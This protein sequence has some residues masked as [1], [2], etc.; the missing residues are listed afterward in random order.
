MLQRAANHA[1]SWWWA[2]HIRT[3]QSKWLEQSLQDM[4]EKV[5][6]MLQLI[7]GDGDSFAKRAEMYYRRRPELICSVEEAYKVF[8]AL[9]DRYDLLSKDFQNANHTI[10]T[11]FPEQMQ[12]GMSMT[13]DDDI[14]KIPEN[15]VIPE[16]NLAKIPQ[17]PKAPAK[18]LK[19]I[20]TKASKQFQVKK[21]KS[22]SQGR[23]VVKSGL[24]KDEALDEINK[25]QKEILSLQTVKEFVKSSYENGIAKYWGIESQV[26]EMHQKISR[27]QDEFN[28]DSVIEDEEA[29]TLIAEA[30]LKSCQETLAMLQEKQDKTTMEARQEYNRIQA[31]CD[32]LQ[33]L[34]DKYMIQQTHNIGSGSHNWS[35]DVADLLQETKEIEELPEKPEENLDVSSLACLSVT[36]LAEKIDLLVNK[37]ITLETAVSSQTVL[38]N[39]L[40]SENDDLN[41]QITNL[42]QG[43]HSITDDTQNISTKV[44]EMEEKLNKVQD[45]T[46]NVEIRNNTL[47]TNFARTRTSLD[48]LSEKLTS[49]KEDDD[50]E[51]DEALCNR[52]SA[53][54]DEEAINLDHHTSPLE[55]STTTVKAEDKEMEAR[56][57][58]DPVKPD[59]EVEGSANLD[60]DSEKSVKAAEEVETHAKLDHASR[61]LSSGNPD[62]EEDSLTARTD[63]SKEDSLTARKARGGVE[64]A[65]EED[66][67]KESN[68]VGRSEQEQQ[69]VEKV[70]RKTGTFLNRRTVEEVLEDES[71]DSVQR[72]SKSKTQTIAEADDEDISW[73]QILLSG[74][75][76]R[77]KILLKEYTTI[78]RNYKEVKKKLNDVEK[79]ERDSQFDMTIQMRELKKAISK[80][81]EEIMNLRRRLMSSNGNSSSDVQ[82][83][84]GSFQ[85]SSLMEDEGVQSVAKE[86]LDM[87]RDIK[88]PPI[89]DEDDEESKVIFISKS[90]SMSR[91]EEK[92]RTH[93]DAILDENLDFWFRFSTAFHQIQ[94]FKT[95]VR[96]LEDEISRHREKRKP[97]IKSEVMPIYK[98]LGEI[99]RELTVWLDQSVPLKDEL[100]NRFAS[101]CN[102]QEEITKA[103]K[104]GMEEDEI[105]FSS[106]QAA[107]L[108]GEVLNMKQ[109]NDKVR[110]EL[111]AGLD[112]VSMLQLQ[113]EK[114][115]TQLNQEFGI[116]TDQSEHRNRVPLRS[117]IF[118]NNKSK[119]PKNSLFSCMHPSRR[120]Q[121]LRAGIRLS[122]HNSNTSAA[123]AAATTTTTTS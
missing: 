111:E 16:M 119:K 102:I 122:T 73:Q 41:S 70:I 115:L 29:R 61:K 8:R 40:R 23:V 58:L 108:Q 9:A 74:M 13:D 56:T 60:P 68:K 38:V 92:L 28:M 46:K 99:Q 14:P 86:V 76:D 53:K 49:V 114:T 5:Q 93:I 89:T 17:V 77:E 106:H 52:S 103:L 6:G 54:A 4:E 95:E 80:R 57:N 81:D 112:H 35:T 72:K 67:K 65:E 1:Y 118:G 90:P 33:S 121:I 27:L 116:S 110:E 7:E 82:E 51:A 64:G 62:E 71:E 78:L 84:G 50:L 123:A 79:K 66:V 37:V 26:M 20:I 83:G 69:V 32:R 48:H 19:S 2:S 101:L 30:A 3:K 42:E 24:T 39:T 15:F 94:K 18:D 55:L 59:G 96:D 104:E 117:F 75:E 31:A 107:K 100:K 44:K 98:H 10:A 43:N 120:F 91:E 12:F 25:L 97:E 85:L 11:V 109:E 88:G 87:T 63:A 113:I 36:Q 45:L 22:Q 21:M 47:E 105:K 34:R